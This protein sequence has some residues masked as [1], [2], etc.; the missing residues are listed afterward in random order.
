MVLRTAFT[1][2]SVCLLVALA[3]DARAASFLFEKSFDVAG[4]GSSSGG[5]PRGVG[6]AG[7]SILVNDALDDQI[8]LIDPVAETAGATYETDP[9][10][11]APLASCVPTQ[12]WARVAWDVTS[13]PGGDIWLVDKSTVNGSSTWL[14]HLNSSGE[15]IE[16]FNAN[17]AGANP[18]GLTYDPRG[19]G[20]LLVT[21]RGSDTVTFFDLSGTALGISGLA[22]SQTPTGIAH[23][24]GDVFLVSDP[25]DDKVYEYLLPS[26]G[27]PATF[28]GQ[29]SFSGI[30]LATQVPGMESLDWDPVAQKLYVLDDTTDRVYVFGLVPEPG[31]GALLGLGLAGLAARRRQG[32]SGRPAGPASPDL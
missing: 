4:F 8:F 7:A 14:I 25:G 24:G 22:P 1:L 21:D 2:A 5:T 27:G 26:G 17:V 31:T 29:S 16:R 23:F 19:G 6:V 30:D 11:C 15:F 32:R 12:E 9:L 13:T 20:S 3:P 18:G 28:L 10:V